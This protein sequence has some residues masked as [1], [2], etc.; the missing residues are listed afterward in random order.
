MIYKK[1]QVKKKIIYTA[2]ATAL[3]ST[4]IFPMYSYADD[5]NVNDVYSYEN[6]QP[7]TVS[8]ETDKNSDNSEYRTTVSNE[9]INKKQNDNANI[10]SFDFR[11]TEVYGENNRK[12]EE[13]IKLSKYDPRGLG[14]MTDVKD[15]EKLGICWTFT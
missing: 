3:L 10:A 9:D 11:G 4:G 6:V 14:Y 15:Q 1:K 5:R 2:L 13:N 12:N 7:D 8:D